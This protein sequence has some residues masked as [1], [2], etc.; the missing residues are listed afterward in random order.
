MFLQSSGDN[1]VIVAFD[2]Y[3][4]VI[5]VCHPLTPCVPVVAVLTK[6]EALTIIILLAK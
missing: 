2:T 5:S 3:L 4:S 1:S 6:N